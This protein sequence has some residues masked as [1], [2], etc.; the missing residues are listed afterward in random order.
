M[1]HELSIKNKGKNN[2]VTFERESREK[3]VLTVF[4]LRSDIELYYT[5]M[6]PFNMDHYKLFY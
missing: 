5:D 4:G 6:L 3:E 1:F 2:G